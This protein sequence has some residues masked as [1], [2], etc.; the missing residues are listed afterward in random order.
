MTAR[1]RKPCC[2]SKVPHTRGSCA[3]AASLERLVA[4]GQPVIDAFNAARPI[5]RVRG[6]ALTDA[7]V[8]ILWAAM[9]AMVND[10]HAPQDTMAPKQWAR[11]TVLL[12]ELDKRVNEKGFGQ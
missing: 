2:S 8:Y 11:A 9:Q 3:A 12:A 7:D 5:A 1:K 10:A 6:Q 4:G